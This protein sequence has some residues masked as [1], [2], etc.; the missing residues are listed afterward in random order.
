[1][2]RQRLVAEGEAAKARVEVR[3]KDLRGLFDRRRSRHC[4]PLGGQPIQY[5]L[6]LLFVLGQDNV[7][8]DRK[9]DTLREP[10][11]GAHWG[12]EALAMS[13]SRLPAHRS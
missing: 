7:H 13:R 5:R 8:A 6:R 12:A 3:P 11:R 2:G 4:S 1:V 10:P 9:E